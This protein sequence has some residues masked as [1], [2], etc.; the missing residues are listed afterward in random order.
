[1]HA[2]RGR[3]NLRWGEP[4]RPTSLDAPPFSLLKTRDGGLADEFALH[5][6]DGAEHLP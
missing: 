3:L 5:L 2:S 1:M 4:D 6:A